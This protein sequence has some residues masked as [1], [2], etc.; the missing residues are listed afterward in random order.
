MKNN[1]TLLLVG[2][3]LAA[4]VFFK[5]RAA[6]SISKITSVPVL[7]VEN[8]TEIKFIDSI[9]PIFTKIFNFE[10]K[11]KDETVN[12][13]QT[14]LNKNTSYIENIRSDRNFN[15]NNI[16]KNIPI[17]EAA[18]RGISPAFLYASDYT[19]IR[20]IT[21]RKS[22]TD[23]DVVNYYENLIASGETMFNRKFP[24]V[25]SGLTEYYKNIIGKRKIEKAQVY[26]EKQQNEINR[27]QEEYQTRF[28][29][30][31]RYG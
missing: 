26:E 12:Y 2:A 1:E 28:G 7:P 18:Y 23:T 11:K 25:T 27:I 21:G 3:L 20:D 5:S 6:S 13:L 30:L 17:R 8:K 16:R 19:R 22:I 4:L 14:E 29:S 9:S 15:E 24:I 10:T 31:S